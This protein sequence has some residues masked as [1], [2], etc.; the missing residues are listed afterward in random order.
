MNAKR[1]EVIDS[2]NRITN[3][4]V[5]KEVCLSDHRYIYFRYDT[6]VVRDCV[7]KRNPRNTDWTPYTMDI[8]VELGDPKGKLN[9]AKDVEF[10][11]NHLT[12]RS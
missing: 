12:G 5:P 4:H 2:S 1:A 3:S 9:S 11:D 8:K 7:Q 10:E 6:I